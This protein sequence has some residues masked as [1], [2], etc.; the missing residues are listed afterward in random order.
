[1]KL[2]QLL[3]ETKNKFEKVGY[4]TFFL[5][6]NV[7][8]FKR[9]NDVKLIDSLLNTF[10][11]DKELFGCL[12]GE[13]IISKVETLLTELQAP[14]SIVLEESKYDWSNLSDDEQKHAEL[15]SDVDYDEILPKK[16]AKLY[17]K[18]QDYYWE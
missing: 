8:D 3:T 14:L 17:N 18:F 6:D 2:K 13:G 11:N 15:L 1:M 5:G 7:P 12:E 4:E 10:E 16:Q 9:F